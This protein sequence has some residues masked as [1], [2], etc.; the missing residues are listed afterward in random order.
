MKE[1]F[2]LCLL[3]RISLSLIFFFVNTNYLPYLA[4]FSFIIGF[5]MLFLFFTRKRLNAFEAGGKTWWHKFRPIH[6]IL[7]VLASIYALK[8]NHLSGLFILADAFLGLFFFV[9]HH[10]F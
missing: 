9:L 2:I 10:F 5:S 7:Y 6:G 8:K 3:A 1:L 4:P